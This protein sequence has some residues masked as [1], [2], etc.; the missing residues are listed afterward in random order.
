MGH[1]AVTSAKLH[2]FSET[3]A[4]G[5]VGQAGVNAVPFSAWIDDWAFSCSGGGGSTISPAEITANGTNFSHSLKLS[6]DKPLILHG[7]KGYQEKLD[8]P[9][10]SHYFSQPFFNV[11]GFLTLNG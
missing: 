3:F 8:R 5:G 1:A 11:D 6:T 2:L 7:D 9:Q 10:A 4:G